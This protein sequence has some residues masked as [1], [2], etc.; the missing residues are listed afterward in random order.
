MKKLVLTFLL[1]ITCYSQ[2]LNITNIIELKKNGL[3][4][5]VII[6]YIKSQ[7]TVQKV[8][9]ITSQVN[10]NNGIKI[11]PESY[12]YFYTH[13][14]YPRTLRYKY[15]VLSPYVKFKPLK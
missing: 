2:N 11:D 1:C 6:A 3:S 9:P 5:E 10:T 13:Y 15:Q 8:L 4:D 7:Q 14:L 12:G